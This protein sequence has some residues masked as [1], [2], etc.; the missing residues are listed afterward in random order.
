M[1]N[2]HVCA[3]SCLTESFEAFSLKF[4]SSK[5]THTM[6]SAYKT[7]HVRVLYNWQQ[8]HPIRS[9]PMKQIKPPQKS[10]VYKKQGKIKKKRKKTSKG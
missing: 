3:Y 8:R 4:L 10:E 5:E 9:D 6:E 7:T 1:R 2:S